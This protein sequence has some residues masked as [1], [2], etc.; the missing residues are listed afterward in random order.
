MAVGVACAGTGMRAAT[1]LLEPLLGDAVDFVR[2]G[3]LIASAL[4]L[5]QQPEAKARPPPLAPR[6]R[7]AAASRHA[8]R[9]PAALPRAS[10]SAA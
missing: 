4:V 6:R 9:A 5:M 3:A 8:A 7:R 1:D 10:A 2:Q